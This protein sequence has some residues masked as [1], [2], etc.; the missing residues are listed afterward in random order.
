MKCVLYV[1]K[2]FVH[3]IYP[4]IYSMHVYTLTVHVI[5][6]PMKLHVPTAAI[7]HGSSHVYMYNVRTHESV[8]S[9]A[10]LD[11]MPNKNLEKFFG[12]TL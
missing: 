7:F 9:K 10:V 8:E 4:T 3:I 2:T 1:H 5:N 6:Y 11:E 12:H